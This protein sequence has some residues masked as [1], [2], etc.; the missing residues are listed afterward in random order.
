MRTRNTKD[1]GT[2]VRGQHKKTK[3]LKLKWN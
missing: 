2:K 3:F 1:L